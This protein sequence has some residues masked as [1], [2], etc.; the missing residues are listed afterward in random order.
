MIERRKM[1]RRRPE[2]ALQVTDAMTGEVVGHLG[3][4]SLEG[5]M[6][7]AQAPIVEDGLYQLTFQLP[8]AH[9]RLHPIEVGAHE[10]W[11]E[12]TN[13]RGHAW[14][15]L[16]LIDISPDDQRMMRDWLK[17]AESIPR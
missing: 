5:M 12:A 6:L 8:D 16:R 2:I 7:V 17:H 9:G 3:N 1:P 4:L 10:L 13:I 14:V 15:G 11:S